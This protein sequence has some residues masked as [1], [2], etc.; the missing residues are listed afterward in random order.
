MKAKK[1]FLC[2]SLFCFGI[3]PLQAKDA[4]TIRLPITL[5]EAVIIQQLLQQI[6]LSTEEIDPLL[7]IQN[8]L[9]QLVARQPEGTEPRQRISLRLPVQSTQDLLIFLQRVTIKGGG[10]KQVNTIIT[11]VQKRLPKDSPFREEKQAASQKVSFSLT[12][13]E[14]SL[15]QQLLL[16]IEVDIPEVS[17]FLAVYNPLEKALSS[18]EPDRE[19][20]L[21]L[22]EQG[23]KNLLIFM[24]R[25][26]IVGS[27][28][29]TV[30]ALRERLRKLQGEIAE[31]E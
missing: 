5:Q 2:F 18:G 23:P 1:F 24:Q 20:V 21:K 29:K 25:F 22:P 12:V 13:Q 9:D 7:A 19:I 10:A 27:Q 14:A 11:K 17:A 26:N 16:Q 8:P 31:K 3:A 15:L 4:S 28:V 6:A 30:Q